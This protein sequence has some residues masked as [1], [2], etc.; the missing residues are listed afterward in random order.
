LAGTSVGAAVF[1]RNQAALL[2]DSSPAVKA[3]RAADLAQWKQTNPTPELQFKNHRP[4]PLYTE[5]DNYVPCRLYN[6]MI[7]GLEPYTLRGFIWFQGDGNGAHP[8]EY[9]EMFTALIQQW[10][11]E[12]R[13]PRLPFYFVEMNNMNQGPQ[14]D[15]VEF[16]SLSVIREQQ[17]GALRLPAVGMVAAID[18]GTP[19]AHFPNKKPVGERLAGLALHDCYGQMGQVESPLF[20]G[21]TIERNHVRL[22]FSAAEGLRVRGGTALKGFAIKGATGNWVWATGK[23]EGEEI[24]VWSDQVPAPTAVRYAWSRNPITSV[25]NG[26]GLPLYPFRTDT[27]TMDGR[28]TPAPTKHQG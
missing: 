1:E 8:Y 20:Q 21:F 14:K 6:A 25:E 5:T 18:V 12:W 27:E 16:N 28:T 2:T 7:H 15:P 13:D 11:G 22:K 10:R 24:V 19:N 3:K 9:S 17:H 23:I 4:K 26:A